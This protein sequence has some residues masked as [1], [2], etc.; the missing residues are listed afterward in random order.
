M[1]FFSHF[2]ACGRKRHRFGVFFAFL[3]LCKET[4]AKKAPLPPF[5]EKGVSP[6]KGG[7]HSRET[8]SHGYGHRRQSRLSAGKMEMRGQGFPVK[9]MFGGVVWKG[10]AQPRNSLS[11]VR[12]PTAKPS[13]CRQDGDAELASPLGGGGICKANAGEGFRGMGILSTEC[14][15]ESLGL[16]AHRSPLPVPL[17]TKQIPVPISTNI[18]DQACEAIL[19]CRIKS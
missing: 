3:C 17:E 1:V 11:W 8:H 4:L 16:L 19:P 13:E 10:P 2:F 15:A 6:P 7:R 5:P 14:F 9:G 18:P 12:A